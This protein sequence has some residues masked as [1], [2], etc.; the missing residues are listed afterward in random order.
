[1]D[2]PKQ[3]TEQRARIISALREAETVCRE[4]KGTDIGLTGQ[5][6]NVAVVAL[7]GV[8]ANL[9]ARWARQS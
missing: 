9:Q 8:R 7:E 5:M 4:L 6:A 2:Q 1:M 3:G